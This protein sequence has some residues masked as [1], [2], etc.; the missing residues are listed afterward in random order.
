[1]ETQQSEDGKMER[2]EEENE[3]GGNI[4]EGCKERKEGRIGNG[5]KLRQKKGRKKKKRRKRK[6]REKEKKKKKRK[7]GRKE[8]EGNQIS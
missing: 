7:R 1:M 8:E 4:W 3:S 5:E 2:H 6:R